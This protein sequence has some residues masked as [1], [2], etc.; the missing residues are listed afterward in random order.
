[1]LGMGALSHVLAGRIDIAFQQLRRIEGCQLLIGIHCK[2][3][4][5]VAA[6]EFGLVRCG[7]C[8]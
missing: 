5:G 2:R 7:I 8:V 1:M 4:H 3:E 6:I